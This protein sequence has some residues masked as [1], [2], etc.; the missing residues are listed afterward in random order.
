MA[1]TARGGD[2]DARWVCGRAGRALSRGRRSRRS[3]GSRAASP[4]RRRQSPARAREWCR[5]ALRG[6]REVGRCCHPLVSTGHSRAGQCPSFGA[7]TKQKPRS[8]G[9]D[10][11]FC[12]SALGGIRTPNLLIRSQM[13]YPL[14]YE[15]WA[16]ESLACR[17]HQDEIGPR[18]PRARRPTSPPTAQ[19]TLTTHRA[20][21]QS[22]ADAVTRRR[23]GT[24]SSR[25]RSGLSTNGQ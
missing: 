18:W 2:P 6:G 12:L 11:G 5:L 7:V 3:R 8:R 19:G 24:T 16:S 1:T 22:Q 10:L 21:P 9:T 14:S 23:N 13:L 25:T 17:L 15:R 4:S 20:S